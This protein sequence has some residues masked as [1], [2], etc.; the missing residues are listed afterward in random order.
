MAKTYVTPMYWRKSVFGGKQETTAGT[1]DYPAVAMAGT[2]VFNATI[3]PDLDVQARGVEMATGGPQPAVV[4]NKPAT[5]SFST[6]LAVADLTDTLLPACG[7]KLGA[8][9]YKPTRDAG[10]WKSWSFCHWRDGLKKSAYGVALDLEMILEVGQRP[11]CNWSGRGIWGG[12]AAEALPASPT[13]VTPL[14]CH[15][16][17]LTHGAG[18]THWQQP[19]RVTIRLNN[20]VMLRGD[21]AV[22]SSTD[23]TGIAH[24][25]IA[26]AAPTIELDPETQADGTLD[27]YDLMSAGTLVAFS[28]TLVTAAGATALVIAAPAVQRTAVSQQQ[29]GDLTTDAIV[30]ACTETVAGSDEISFTFTGW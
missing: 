28:A 1:A 13:L 3:E 29:R 25:Y 6:E 17:T 11:I 27:N 15:G 2:G 9:A 21:M 10:D 8:G 22:A 12:Q 26:S 16:M 14:W 4:G 19:Q 7:L 5:V 30:L 24:A 18:P 23:A 20:Q